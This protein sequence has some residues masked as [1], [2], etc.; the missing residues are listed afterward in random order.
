MAGT[1]AKSRRFGPAAAA[2]ASRPSVAAETG[3]SVLG[4]RV[5]TSEDQRRHDDCSA[6]APAAAVDSMVPQVLL[7]GRA[8]NMLYC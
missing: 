8:H 1:T 4:I 6:A 7:M 3:R 5:Q 2:A